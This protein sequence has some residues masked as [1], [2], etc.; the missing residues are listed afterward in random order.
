MLFGAPWR[1]VAA[2]FPAVIVFVWM[3]AIATLLHLDRFHKDSLPFVAWAALYMVTPFL[4][5][6][7]VLRNHRRCGAPTARRCRARAA[8]RA[9]RRRRRRCWPSGVLFLVAPTWRSTTGRGC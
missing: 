9:R 5:P 2:G 7:L 4:V 3:A 1:A 8:A 6:W